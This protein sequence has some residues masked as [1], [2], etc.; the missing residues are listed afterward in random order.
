M[1]GSE[2]F[3][4]EIAAAPDDDAPR[5]VYAD[6]LEERGDPRGEF[7]RIQCELARFDG[8]QFGGLLEPDSDLVVRE[9]DLLRDNEARWL[10]PLSEFCQRC[11][12]RRGFVEYVEISAASFVEHCERLFAEHPIRSASFRVVTGDLSRLASCRLL[13][14]L[15][16]I[17]IGS[18]WI[19]HAD[20]ESL[21]AS[22]HFPRLTKLVMLGCDLGDA[23]AR[24]IATS[25]GLDRLEVLD[26]SRN[27]VRN[28][29]VSA[30]A[31][32]PHLARLKALLLNTNTIRLLGA[33]SLAQ[34][35]YLQHLRYVDLRN[36]PIPQR[37]IDEVRDRFGRSACDM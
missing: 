9:A 13:A 23:A 29:G 24:L 3:L 14:R 5:L 18:H 20:L 2:P 36:N 6:W 21:L 31:S 10:G 12:F 35:P 26:L 32:S 4:Q 34:S 8:L 37:G 16:G 22:P 1:I 7:I 30:I 17:S 15:S 25:P 33:R 28:D 27:A 19:D 11:T